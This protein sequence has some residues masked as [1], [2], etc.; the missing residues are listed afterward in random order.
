VAGR[1]RQALLG[2]R[3]RIRQLAGVEQR[4]HARGQVRRG[5]RAGGALGEEEGDRDEGCSQ[6]VL[7]TTASLLPFGI[8][9]DAG[10]L[11][12]LPF[13]RLLS[14]DARATYEGRILGCAAAGWPQ[15]SRAAALRSLAPGKEKPDVSRH[16]AGIFE[17]TGREVEPVRLQVPLP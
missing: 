4:L 1:L 6:Q 5:E 10:H 13:L 12:V 11:R 2:E 14:G 17:D 3:G 16:P 7:H 15:A 9:A 8:V